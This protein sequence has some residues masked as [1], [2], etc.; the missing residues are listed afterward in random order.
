[1]KVSRESLVCVS[2]S[3]NLSSIYDVTKMMTLFISHHYFFSVSFRETDN[4]LLYFT[5]LSGLSLFKGRALKVV[6][7][8]KYFFSIGDDEP[9]LLC[10]FVEEQ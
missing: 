9:L 2:L 1:M 5:Y 7:D 3:L 8:L 4:V 10:R 6:Y